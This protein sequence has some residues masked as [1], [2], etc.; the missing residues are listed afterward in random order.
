MPILPCLFLEL[1]LNLPLR[2]NGNNYFSF[3]ERHKKTPKTQP[4]EELRVKCGPKGPTNTTLHMPQNQRHSS[5]VAED[6]CLQIC[7]TVAYSDNPRVLVTF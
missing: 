1:N 4:L 2:R 5:S 7:V 6:E 3:F